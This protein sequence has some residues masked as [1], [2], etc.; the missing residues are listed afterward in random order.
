MVG[1]WRLT[2]ARELWQ[3]DMVRMQRAYE[4]EQYETNDRDGYDSGMPEILERWYV[5]DI[6]RNGWVTLVQ[7]RRRCIGTDFRGQP[8]YNSLFD[9]TEQRVKMRR[10]DARPLLL[11]VDNYL[12][13]SDLS[14]FRDRWERLG[15]DAR[16][17]DHRMP[18]RAA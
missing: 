3:G 12:A 10:S 8:R 9:E 11:A 7:E 6:T 5:E 18:V 2:K 1:I 16:P 17:S 4:G 15:C 14:V 13:D